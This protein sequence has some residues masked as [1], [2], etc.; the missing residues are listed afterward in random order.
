MNASTCEPRGAGGG[1]DA[2]ALV[3]LTPNELWGIPA[4]E[5]AELQLTGLKDRFERLVTRIPALRK[6]AAEQGIERIAEI[7][8]AAALLFRHNVYKSYPLSFLEK[9]DFRRLTRWLDGL[10]TFDL[11]QLD[12]SHCESIDEWIEF[13]DRNTEI[14]VIHS[15]G[16]SGKLSFLPRSE[17]EFAELHLKWQHHFFEGFGDEGEHIVEGIERLPIVTPSYRFGALGQQRMIEHIAKYWHRDAEV[18]IV[19]LH[20]TRMSADALSLGGRLLAAEAKGELGQFQSSPQIDGPA[21]GVSEGGEG[22][23]ASN[24]DLPGR[25][26]EAQRPARHLAGPVRTVLRRRGGRQPQGHEPYV[27]RR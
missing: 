13:L 15:S 19:A 14:R 12:A 7:D 2:A 11:S 26:R 25:D 1:L 9:S 22:P 5:I 21:G 20:P 6:L 4:A 10:T 24:G 17:A 23:P 3:G 8:D 18:P 27:R 16:T